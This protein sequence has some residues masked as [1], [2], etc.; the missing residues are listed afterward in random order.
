MM[1]GKPLLAIF[2]KNSS[3]GKIIKACN[4]GH[5]FTFDQPAELIVL[6]M[7]DFIASLVTGKS[8]NH[9]IDQDEFSKYSAESMTLK[10][11]KLF[12]QVL[13]S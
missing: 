5:L 3:A 13:H 7:A 1:V 11:V 9:T 4:A 6:G 10:Q 12:N 2:H 8:L